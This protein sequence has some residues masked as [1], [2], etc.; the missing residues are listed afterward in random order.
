MNKL[1]YESVR[2][3]TRRNY[4]SVWK[5]FNQFFIRLDI[6]SPTW[7]ER[8]T[9]FVAHLVETHHRFQTCKSYILAIKKIL[10]EDGV[11]LSEDKCLLVSITRACKLKNDRVIARL[12]IQKGLLEL[13][14][15]WTEDYFSSLNQEYLCTLYCTL[16]VTAYYGMFRVGEVTSGTHPVR[17]TDIK[18]G[19]NKNKILFILRSSK[20]HGKDAK[21][22]LIKIASRMKSNLAVPRF[23]YHGNFHT[24]P[25]YWLRRYTQ[26]RPGFAEWSEPFFIFGDHSPVKPRHFRSTLHLILQWEGLDPSLYNTHSLRIRRS[27]DLLALG[28]EISMIQA[29]GRWKSNIVFKYLSF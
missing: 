8:L 9:L 24:C 23:P 21:P 12:P 1:K 7:E 3:S 15:K 19:H 25:Y 2:D 5:T 11:E 17:V 4:Y 20:T 16:L 22:Q 13:L 26:A 14:M 27:F 29:L 6:K 10:R 18:V 28:V